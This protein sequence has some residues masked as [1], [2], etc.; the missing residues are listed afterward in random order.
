M[1]AG[2]WN[3]TTYTSY[4]KSKGLIDHTGAA[5]NKSAKEIFIEERLNQAL[6][7]KNVKIRESRDSDEHPEST[8]L[9]L[10]L[11]VTGSMNVVAKYIAQQALPKLMTEIYKRKPVSDPQVMFMG[12][13]DLEAAGHLQVSQFESDIRIA[14]QLQLMWLENKGGGNNYESYALPWYFLANHTIL[15]CFEKRGKK[16]YAISMGDENPTPYLFLNDMKG[17]L[18][19]TPQSKN[20]DKLSGA[21]ILEMVQKKYNVFHVITEEGSFARSNLSMVR[22]SW[23]ELL[24]ESNVISLPDY[25]KLSEVVISAIQIAEGANPDDVAKSWE[26]AKLADLVSKTLKNIKRVVEV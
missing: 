14:E 10:I 11:D 9:A 1:G 4:A 6:D 21:E 12:V 2:S 8:A 19:Y 25:T 20:K 16:G 26:D 5:T 13:D 17:V 3:P 15:D 24:G 23:K 22:N 7:P 18:G